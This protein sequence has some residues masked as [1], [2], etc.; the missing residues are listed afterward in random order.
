MAEIILHQSSS[1][2][3]ISTQVFFDKRLSYKAKG[4]LVQLFSISKNDKWQSDWQWSVA[5][6]C[7]LATDGKASVDSAIHELEEYGYLKREQKRTENGRT[8]GYEYHVYE[9]PLTDFQKTEK[10][11]TENQPQYN[12]KKNNSKKENNKEVQQEIFEPEVVEAQPVNDFEYFWGDYGY[13]KDRKS[14]ERAWKKLSASEKR[15]AVDYIPA[16]KQDCISHNREMRYPATYL[17]QATWENEIV[18]STTTGNGMVES[19]M[20]AES[21]YQQLKI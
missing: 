7:A 14:A 8:D 15:K 12:N 19:A 1:H 16:Y 9:E 3:S 21:V 18:S 20:I 5:G 2:M 11:I 13:K 6:L 4:L 10:P 17:N